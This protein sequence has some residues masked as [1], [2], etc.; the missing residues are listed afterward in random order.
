MDPGIFLRSRVTVA[1][2]IATPLLL[3]VI[4]HHGTRLYCQAVEVRLVQDRA[5]MEILPDLMNGQHRARAALDRFSSGSNEPV[6]IDDLGLLV[7]E[8]SDN[9]SFQLESD[10]VSEEAQNPDTKDGSWSVQVAGK[11][12]LLSMM[13]FLETLQQPKHLV[14]V[15]TASVR[16]LTGLGHEQT[17]RGRFVLY[18]SQLNPSPAPPKE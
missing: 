3:I 11:G 6:A 13:R 16:L 15:E 8:A 2:W 12:T 5:M 1:A 18:Y 4:A 17:Y 10:Q 9:S 7:K 14:T